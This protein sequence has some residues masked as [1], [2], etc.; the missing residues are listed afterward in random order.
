MLVSVIMS[1]YNGAATIKY[2]VNSILEQTLSDFEFIICDDGSTDETPHFLQELLQNDTRIRLIT[3]QKNMGAAYAR[4][5]ALH[6]SQG[7]FIAIMD[8]DDYSYPERLFQQVHFL[9]KNP[10]IAFVGS[11]G[12]FFYE[13]PG[14]MK[15][16]YPFYEAPRSDD[17]LMTL[18]FV[19]ASL[20]F[21]K[22]VLQQ[23]GGYCESVQA[24]RS[25]DYELLMRL[26][27]L[28]YRGTNLNERL[29]GIRF[30]PAIYRRR[31][32]RYRIQEVR[33]KW[34]GFSQLGLLPKGIPYALKPLIVGLIPPSLLE[35]MKERY[36]RLR[37]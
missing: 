17:F 3:N 10:H 23:A 18:P 37:I 36:Y 2:A 29:Y 12:Q 22:E 15:K 1:V 25:E 28:G 6:L 19:H 11:R 24:L 33:I 21:R 9:R 13:A 34:R 5:R 8:A 32:Y 4:N 35:P 14:D 7:P 16:G 31:K 20:M 26:Y 30:D 27:S